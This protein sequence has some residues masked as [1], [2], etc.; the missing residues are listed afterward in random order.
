MRKYMRRAFLSGGVLAGLCGVMA[1]LIVGSDFL[2]RDTIATNSAAKESAALR[3]VFGEAVTYEDPVL[4]EDR[5]YSY[6][7]KYWTVTLDGTEVGRV[8]RGFGRN[9]YGD[10]SLLYGVALDFSLY[11]VVTLSN[12]ESYGTTLKEN[13]LD[14]LSSA[15]DKDAAVDEV[16]CGATYGAKLCRDIIREG[17]RHYREAKAK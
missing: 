17:Q 14:P 6:L 10:V 1:A 4:V 16:K 2:T 3:R 9:G 8:Y 11:N 5:D 12:T 7:Q 15:S 13:Y